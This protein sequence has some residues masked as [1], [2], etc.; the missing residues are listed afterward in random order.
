MNREQ[1]V[2]S[3]KA[4][5]SN[6][7]N[8]KNI[9]YYCDLYPVHESWKKWT[10]NLG[11]FIQIYN[12]KKI[13]SFTNNPLNIEEKIITDLYHNAHP[14][15]IA[16][17]SKKV[18]IA[19]SDDACF[20]WFLGNDSRLRLVTYKDGNWTKNYPVLSCGI[21]SILPIVSLIDSTIK[22][23]VDILNIR[24]PFSSK[25]H[26]S[27]VIDWPPTDIAKHQIKN[28]KIIELC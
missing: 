19:D 9:I 13:I 7:T 6:E 16:N 25:I 20:G 26:S 15:K 8:I 5:L 17:I 12:N 22:G 1:A 2:E 14:K 24:G 4:F 28:T 18:F 11:S 23:R 21:N 3:I 10:D 27:W